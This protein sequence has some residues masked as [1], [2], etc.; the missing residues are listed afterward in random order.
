MN[1]SCFYA[2][3]SMQDIRSILRTDVDGVLSLH[4]MDKKE[5]ASNRCKGRMNKIAFGYYF[6]RFGENALQVDAIVT[7]DMWIRTPHYFVCGNY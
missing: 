3:H 7:I 6:R 2:N 4:S 5:D 1:M